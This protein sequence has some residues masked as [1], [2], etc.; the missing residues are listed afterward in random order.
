MDVLEHAAQLRVRSGKRGKG[1][2]D[3]LADVLLVAKIL[4][5][6]EAAPL[7]QYDGGVLA[8][9]ELVRDVLHEH[10][11]E[12]IILVLA[13]VHAAS[14]LIAELVQRRIHVVLLDGHG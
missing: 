8:S 6:V 12:N 5:V 1:D 4:E 9:L 3:L 7:W 14:K 2:V 11:R 13:W 10:E